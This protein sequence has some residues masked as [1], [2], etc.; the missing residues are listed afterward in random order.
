ML[1]TNTPWNDILLHLFKKTPLGLHAIRLIRWLIHQSELWALPSIVPK[2]TILT[3][4]TLIPVIILAKV[5]NGLPSQEPKLYSPF[6]S[7][8]YV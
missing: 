3:L 6:S 1:V 5:S 7:V 8:V 2:P 4:D